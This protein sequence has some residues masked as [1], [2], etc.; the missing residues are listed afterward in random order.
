VLALDTSTGEVI[1][2]LWTEAGRG[3]SRGRLKP[4]DIAAV[5][6]CYGTTKADDRIP[7]ISA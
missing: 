4:D 5:A 3:V 2:E 6:A 1:G 7:A